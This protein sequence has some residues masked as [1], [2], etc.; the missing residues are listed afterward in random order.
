MGQN[1]AGVYLLSIVEI[2]NSVQQIGSSVIF[3]VNI[4][5]LALMW[6]NDFIYLF[7][8][9]GKD[10]NG[11]VSSSGTAALLKFDILHSLENYKISVY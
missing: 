11:S 7:D 3:F 4:Y 9:Y 1:A 10:E 6:E 2:V 5:I 8:S